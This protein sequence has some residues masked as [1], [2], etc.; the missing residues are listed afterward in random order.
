MPT[1]DFPSLQRRV[2]RV[3]SQSYT[4]ARADGEERHR[5][6]PTAW[7]TSVRF[8]HLYTCPPHSGLPIHKSSAGRIRILQPHSNLTLSVFPAHLQCTAL[9][10]LV[11]ES[12]TTSLRRSCDLEGSERRDLLPG[13]IQGRYSINSRYHI[14]N[15]YSSFVARKH[16]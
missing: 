15:G 6:Y 7:E 4:T 12:L 16:G 8:Q 10:G 14:P 13:F 2:Y 5:C 11:S 1:V 9:K 3:S